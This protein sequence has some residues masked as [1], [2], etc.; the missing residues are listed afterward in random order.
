[1]A[2]VDKNFRIRHGLVVQGS[3]ATVNGNQVLTEASTLADLSGIDL[4][5]LADGKVLIYNSSTSTWT[6]GDSG[7]SIAISETAPPSPSAGDTWFDSSTGKTYIYYVDANSSQWIEMSNL[8]DNNLISKLADVDLSSLTDGHVLVY[9]STS[10]KWIAATLNTDAVAEG[11]SN[12]YF[13]DARALSA[14]QSSY[15]AYADQAEADAI[16]SAQAYTDS[17]ISSIALD[18]ISDVNV[19]GVAD[20]NSLVYD[21]ETSSWVPGEGGGS[22]ASITVSE[23]PPS[24]PES[25]NLWLD[26]VTGNTYIYYSDADTNQWVQTAGPNIV[27]NRG[28]NI[29]V[30]STAPGGPVSGDLWYDPSEGYTYLYYVDVDS[31]QW[32]QFGLNRNGNNGTNGT[33]GAD[34]VGIPVGGTEGQALVKSSSTDYA[35]EWSDVSAG[36]ETAKI[37][38]SDSIALDFSDNIQ[39]EQ[40]AVA[41]DVT[42]TASN[43][44]SGVKKTIY[45]QGDTVQRSLTFP[46]GWNFITDKPT[47]IGASKKNILDLNSFG[48]SESTT[49]AIWLGASAFEPIVATGGT[50]F[51][52][53][54]DG[55][56]YQV[57]SFTTVGASTFNVTDPGTLKE[58][59]YLIVGGGGGGGNTVGGGGGAG[60]LAFGTTEITIL[61]HSIVVG[62]GGVGVGG[63]YPP[64]TNGTGS[65]AF[66]VAVLGGGAG[67]GY[68]EAPPSGSFGST[69][70]LG[71]GTSGA[72]G[73]T[74][75]LG[76]SG[77]VSNANTNAGAGGGGFGGV[78]GNS[79]SSAA[80]AGGGG[81]TSSIT[82]AA[83]QYAGGGGGGGR[84]TAGVDGAGGA[85]RAGN[86]GRTTVG[87]NAAANSGSGGGGGGYVGPLAGG[88]GGSGI[89]I[90]RYPIT[91]PN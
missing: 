63:E 57:H 50:E 30:S 48:T 67:G 31:S 83:V 34:G 14:V 73:A 10:E 77:G 66:N 55:V 76:N 47:A 88:A 41:G 70:G 35:V 33:D 3:S 58:V 20:G 32:V 52:I 68:N 36:S 53:S 90:V 82:G 49:V 62:A 21:V 60:G 89:V 26:S 25:G 12:L 74:A 6:I 29:T 2:T 18:D 13:T 86:G 72:N 28:A 81:Y 38:T 65:S 19:S 79:T 22:S 42:F 11:A 39:L 37:I 43:Y 17:S 45:L 85:A 75:T 44:T 54:L 71:G 91:D 51:T 16:T 27:P 1:M 69:G 64:G 61:N 24:S 5:G 59:E 46:A 80:G 84:N 8:G 7:S 87:G 56:N 40:R 23:T 9:N 78:G 15:E 4:S